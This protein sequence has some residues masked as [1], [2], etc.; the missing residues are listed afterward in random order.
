MLTAQIIGKG[1][2]Y[3]KV[4]AEYN[5]LKKKKKIEQRNKLF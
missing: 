3:L 1:T 4:Q 2:F 5:A